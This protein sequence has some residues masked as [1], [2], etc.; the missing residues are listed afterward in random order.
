MQT[1]NMS[2]YAIALAVAIVVISEIG[3]IAADQGCPFD[4]G[5]CQEYCNQQSCGLGYCGHFAWIQCICRKCGDVS[6][7]LQSQYLKETCDQFKENQLIIKS[8]LIL[9]QLIQTQEWSYY[10]KIRFTNGYGN[11]T[12]NQTELDSIGLK[13]SNQSASLPIIVIA[14]NNINGTQTDTIQTELITFDAIDDNLQ[15]TNNN[16][17]GDNNSDNEMIDMLTTNVTTT[18]ALPITQQQQPA[19]TTESQEQASGT[20]LVPDLTEMTTDDDND[21]NNNNNNDSQS[22]DANDNDNNKSNEIDDGT[23]TDKLLEL[24]EKHYNKL[25]STTTTTPVPAPPSPKLSNL[26]NGLVNNNNSNNKRK[27]NTV[28]SSE[29]ASMM[30]RIQPI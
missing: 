12:V 9:Y 15:S 4:N 6:I 28:T 29:V 2:K 27:R 19:G 14:T 20:L 1:T 30:Y 16:N 13:L 3:L 22:N 5:S 18:A 8:Y 7:C 17:S 25:A 23:E 24:A 21:N 26:I 11:K 10:D